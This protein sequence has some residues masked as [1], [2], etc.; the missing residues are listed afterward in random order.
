MKLARKQYIFFSILIT[1]FL[2]VFSSTYIVIN[3]QA[4]PTAYI[5]SNRENYVSV[6]DTIHDTVAATVPVG[7]NPTGVAISPDGTKVY[8]TNNNSNSISVISTRDNSVMAIVNDLNTPIGITITP[9]GKKI[10][11]VNSIQNGYISVINTANNKVTATIKTGSFP[12]GIATSPDGKRVYV[13]SR[14]ENSI[15][16]VSVIDTATNKV[17]ASVPVEKETTEIAVTPNGDTVYVTNR[18]SNTISVI[19]TATNAL[20]PITPSINV[21]NG[22][23]GVVVTPNGDTVYVTNMNSNTVSIIN[24]E[25]NSIIDTVPVG[26]HPKGIAVTPDGSK[27]YAINYDSN[28]ISV[29]DTATRKVIAT[30]NVGVY[31]TA[32]GQFIGTNSNFPIY[33]ITNNPRSDTTTELTAPA[34]KYTFGQII[35]LTATIDTPSQGI[36]KL[37]GTVTFTDGTLALGTATVNSGIAILA[38]S[39]LS[40]GSHSITAQYS[41]DDNFKP[42][43]SHIS[44]LMVLDKAS[45]DKQ[46]GSPENP[47]VD[48]TAKVDTTAQGTEKPTGTVYFIDGKTQIGSESLKI[49]QPSPDPPPLLFLVVCALFFALLFYKLS[50][51]IRIIKIESLAKHP[52]YPLFCTLIGAIA[53][54]IFGK[55]L[56]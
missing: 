9:D 24:T 37:S 16:Q 21:G 4:I 2:F 53:S 6:I 13:A 10:Y 22:P 40:V 42:S 1:I 35:T 36:K 48:I 46:P 30:V 41:G 8:V 27:V 34:N 12:T 25:T 50:P 33:P 44:T 14:L 39:V 47:M 49:D 55:L 17:T 31:P 38:T 18:W 15:Y 54:V 23:W 19:D 45:P 56:K 43:S 32:W 11:V 52:L 26:A 29:I 20:N 7:S 51:L 3:A 5:P 28:N